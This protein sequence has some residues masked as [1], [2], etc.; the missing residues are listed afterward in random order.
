YGSRESSSGGPFYR[1]IQNQSSAAGDS[2]LYNYMNSGHEQTEA[3]RTNVLYGPYALSFT[4]GCT[5]AIPDFSWMSSLNLTGWVPAAQR[6]RWG[7][8]PSPT[9]RARPPL[10]GES[11][12]GTARRS[13]S[14]TA[15]TSRTCTLRTCG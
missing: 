4:T 14:T 9:T 2:E 1:D 15:R 3:V 13:N 10:S 5:P 12:T 11:A 7:R 8:S 6:G